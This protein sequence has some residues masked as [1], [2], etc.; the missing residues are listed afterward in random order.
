MRGLFI[1]NSIDIH[2]F[3]YL[4]RMYS[5]LFCKVLLPGKTISFNVEEM[6][7]SCSHLFEFKTWEMIAGKE[8]CISTAKL[9]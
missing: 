9:S 1:M 8:L 5:F 7:Y 4:G 3:F 2:L 6:K